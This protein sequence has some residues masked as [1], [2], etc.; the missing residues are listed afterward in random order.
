RAERLKEGAGR[1]RRQADEMYGQSEEKLR[2]AIE[3]SRSTA[4]IHALTGAI[5]DIAAQTSLLSLNASI[6]AARAGE[7]GRGFAV[8]AGEIRKLAENSRETAAEIQ[9][10][11]G[12]VV[13]AVENLVEG[14]ENMLRFVDRQVLKDYDSMQETGR[15]YSEDAGYIHELVTDFSATSGQLLASIQSM[16]S[17]I[18]ETSSAANEGAEGAGSIASQAEQIIS[19]SGGIVAE[20]EEIKH[21]SEQLLHT[22]SKFKA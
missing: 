22:V 12:A 7:A 8:V 10:V 15:Q 13:A 1:S 21:S 18:S 9:E 14:A 16:H 2:K 4:Q 5:L 20:M 11:T 19:K 3:Q 6:E 17:A